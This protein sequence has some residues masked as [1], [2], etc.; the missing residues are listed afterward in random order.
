MNGAPGL[1]LFSR[2]ALGGGAEPDLTGM[3][4]TTNAARSMGAGITTGR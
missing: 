4:V 2:H 3:P 1:P